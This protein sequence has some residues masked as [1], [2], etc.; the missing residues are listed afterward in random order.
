MR[1]MTLQELDREAAA[2]DAMVAQSSDL[3]HFCSSTDWI[4]PAALALMPDRDPFV[5]RGEHG[6]AALMRSRHPAGF[7]CLEPLEA[8]WGLGCPLIGPEPGR[9]VREFVACLR[10]AP[11]DVLVLCGLVPGSPLFTTL[12]HGLSARYQ[13]GTGPTMRRYTADLRGGYDVFLGR[14]SGNL[15][16]ALKQARRRADAAGI[17]FVAHRPSTSCDAEALYERILEI[18]RRSWKGRMGTG[19][20][21]GA[22]NGFYRLMVRRLLARGTLRLMFAQREGRDVA[23][24]LGALLGDAYRGLQASFDDDYAHLSLGS[25][26]HD[27]QIAELCDEGV[28]AYDLG[29]EVEYKKRWGEEGLETVTLVAVPA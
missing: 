2:F 25:L 24:V 9:L 16:K 11:G 10:E 23:Y 8:M 7:R 6:Y 14:R 21:D 26:M 17:S 19:I 1:P 18:E 15:R 12:A 3:D 27:R 20:V 4:L 22:M 28:A 5:R 29:S 13:V